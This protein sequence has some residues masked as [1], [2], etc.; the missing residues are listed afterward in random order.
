MALGDSVH[1]QPCVC[2]C[3][4]VWCCR[5]LISFFCR[6]LEKGRGVRVCLCGLEWQKGWR[7]GLHPKKGFLS[8][9]QLQDWQDAILLGNS[10]SQPVSLP[11]RQPLTPL[12]LAFCWVVTGLALTLH[13]AGLINCT[14]KCTQGG[15]L[16]SWTRFAIILWLVVPLMALITKTALSPLSFTPLSLCYLIN[17]PP[18]HSTLDST[19]VTA[20]PGWLN[21]IWVKELVLVIVLV[22]KW[23]FLYVFLCVYQSKSKAER[24]KFA[25]FP[26]L[27]HCKS[28]PIVAVTG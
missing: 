22:W 15:T 9:W 8:R 4:S 20:F 7:W 27:T 28:F 18:L 12:N 24:E 26:A 23:P 10:V 13:V 21:A 1:M 2:V 11:V 19:L 14:M 6:I 16:P 3:L 5:W 25:A 17:T